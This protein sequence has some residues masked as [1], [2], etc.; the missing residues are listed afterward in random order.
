MEAHMRHFSFFLLLSFCVF[1]NQSSARTNIWQQLDAPNGGITLALIASQQD[2]FAGTLGGGVFR[3]PDH[4]RSWQEVNNGLSDKD[5]MAL[6]SDGNGYLFAGTFGGGVFRSTDI[7]NTW[8]AVNTGLFSNEVVS[9]CR[10]E[11]GSL[12]AGTSENGVFTS[13]NLGESW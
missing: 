3:S 11:R 5:V 10:D 7:G 4:G 13:T 12:Y 6:M 9:L 8:K 1:L 2:V